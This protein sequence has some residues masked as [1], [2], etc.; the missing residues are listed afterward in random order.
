MPVTPLRNVRVADDLWNGA[1]SQAWSDDRSLSD[2][3]REF[4]VI[5]R[6]SPD[7]VRLFFDNYRNDTID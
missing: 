3:I 2:V 7:A 5:Y 6:D 1:T 4:L